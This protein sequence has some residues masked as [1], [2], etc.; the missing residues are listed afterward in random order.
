MMS[1]LSPLY[2]RGPFDLRPRLRDIGTEDSKVAAL[3]GWRLLETPGHTP[4][5][6]SFW[7]EADRVLLPGDAFCTTRPESFFE[8]AVAQKPEVHGPPSYFTSDWAA[9]GR[10][11]QR[12]AELDAALVAPGHRKPLSGPTVAHA[13]R[14]LAVRFGDVAVPENAKHDAA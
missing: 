13:V 2:P 8:A 9:A 7:R 12:L 4:G 14:Q 3:P 11:V 10:S 1:L 5:H 6:I